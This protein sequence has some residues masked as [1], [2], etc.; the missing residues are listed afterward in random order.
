MIPLNNNPAHKPSAGEFFAG[1]D[2]LRGIAVL[3]VVIGHTAYFNPGTS[4]FQHLLLAA[5]KTGGMG[6]SI[7]FV[8]SGFLISY[9]VIKS[10]DR[11]DLLA[12]VMRRAAKIYPPFVLSVVVFAALAYYWKGP[13]NLCSSAAAYLTTLANFTRGWADINGVCW[14]LMV[15]LHFYIAFPLI[16]LGLRKITCHAEWA[17]FWC[18]LLIPAALRFYYYGAILDC[19]GDMGRWNFQAHLFP[20]ALDNF[21]L[22]ILF[23]ILYKQ[24]KIRASLGRIAPV[25]AHTGAVLLVAIYALYTALEYSISITGKPIAATYELFCY[26]PAIA[27]F[28]LLFVVLLPPSS[29]LQRFLSSSTLGFIGII[30]YEWFLFH[31]PPTALIQEVLGKSEGSMVIYL[32]KTL[33]PFVGTLAASAMIYWF[34]SAPILSWT[35][36]MLRKRSQAR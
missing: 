13:D 10:A 32:S 8:L 29:V 11:F 3:S 1:L 33:L 26:L 28:L 20:R 14:S 7:F 6:V 16:Y 30:S 9:S 5:S 2:G 21:A 4:V 24:T 36:N 15:E 34:Y 12:Y 22:G 19:G 35:R 31:F 18:F 27:T 25:L 23:S 17:T